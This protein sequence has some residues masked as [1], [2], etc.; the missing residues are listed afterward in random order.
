MGIIKTIL[1]IVGIAFC[2]KSYPEQS[3]AVAKWIWGVAWS[4]G[5]WGYLKLKVAS[6]G[7]V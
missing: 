4:V 6:G 3:T 1:L 7:A 5:F 2:V